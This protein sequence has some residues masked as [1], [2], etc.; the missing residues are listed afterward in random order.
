MIECSRKTIFLRIDTHSI[1]FFSEEILGQSECVWFSPDSRRLLLATFN[2][3]NVGL[4]TFK[5]FDADP[6][7]LGGQFLDGHPPFE[8]SVRYSKV[9][10]IF[11]FLL[12]YVLIFYPSLIYWK[13]WKMI[14][15]LPVKLLVA[16]MIVYPPSLMPAL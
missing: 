14:F 15:Y 2:D 6:G 5:E 16:A 4:V 9:R 12:F 11:S 7:T 3:S 13:D 1:F 8:M 10:F